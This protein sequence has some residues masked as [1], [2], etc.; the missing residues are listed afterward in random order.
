MIEASSLR[1]EKHDPVER[2]SQSG[3]NDQALHLPHNIKINDQTKSKMS[4][5]P[6][7][8]LLSHQAIH[9]A[10][11]DSFEVLGPS[12]SLE[13]F[14]SEHAEE[15]DNNFQVLEVPMAAVEIVETDP[16]ESPLP[17]AAPAP[18]RQRKRAALLS[19]TVVRNSPQEKLGLGLAMTS[20]SRGGKLIIS[21]IKPSG[22]LSKSPFRIG[23]R[24]VS[25]N[26]ISCERMRKSEAATFLRNVTGTLTVVVQNESGDS[27]LVESMIWKP[28]PDSKTGLAVVSNGYSQA[29]VSNIR[30]NGLFERSLLSR[31]DLILSVN[32]IPCHVLDSKEVADIVMRSQDSVT[33]VAE[34]KYES[35]VVVAMAQ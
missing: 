34:R 14:S 17:C 2:M 7:I 30:P 27:Q 32:H 25:I 24:L 31:K 35:A 12:W 29:R 11:A 13:D 1:D 4:M 5:I 19:A 16:V 8:E 9:L 23:D 26:N 20:S 21:S 3:T 18:T 10:D 15:D 22:L 6:T 33:V 28:E